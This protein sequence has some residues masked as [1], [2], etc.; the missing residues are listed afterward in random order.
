MIH[1]DKC[2]NDYQSQYFFAVEGICNNCF[3][4]MSPQEQQALI[5]ENQN[6]TATQSPNYAL[7]KRVGFGLRFASCILDLIIRN[8]IVFVIVYLSGNL[9]N[10]LTIVKTNLDNY[11]QLSQEIQIALLPLGVAFA[12][13]EIIYFSM[14][15]FFGA[16]PGKMIFNL[17]IANLEGAKA[18][19]INLAL[20]CLI[21]NGNLIFSLIATFLITEQD[22]LNNR[23]SIFSML[24]LFCLLFF[25][26]G[27][28]FYIFRKETSAS[29]YNC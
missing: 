10:I 1:C 2:G 20:R 8:I 6:N 23:G 15:I 14:E 26:V 16:T 22:I 9:P 4:K 19:I 28:F 24:S 25:F 5:V 18:Q 7:N 12:L 11:L 13:S 29:R 27:I 3:Q 17:K 21:K